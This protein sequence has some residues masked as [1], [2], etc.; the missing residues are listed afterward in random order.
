MGAYG[1]G[2]RNLAAFGSVDCFAL[3]DMD[4]RAS[5]AMTLYQ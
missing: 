5:L 2:L 4:R 3:I 1:A